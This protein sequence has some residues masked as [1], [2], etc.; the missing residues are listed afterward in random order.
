MQARNIHMFLDLWCLLSGVIAGKGRRR[1]EGSEQGRLTISEERLPCLLAVG[2]SRR[3]HDPAATEGHYHS[4]QIW[5]QEGYRSN[6]CVSHVCAESRSRRA[7]RA[8]LQNADAAM[9]LRPRAPEAD[10]AVQ[11]GRRK[12]GWARDHGDTIC[13][14]LDRGRQA[15][16]QQGP[17]VVPVSPLR[18]DARLGW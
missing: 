6:G 10:C 18:T 12:R 11:S 4:C 1:W 13:H 3:I 17:R 7:T 8:P 9:P 14:A 16:Q 15:S 5:E 2:Q